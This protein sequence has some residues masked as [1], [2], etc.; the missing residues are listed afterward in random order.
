MFI[1]DAEPAILTPHIRKEKHHKVNVLHFTKAAVS[2]LILPS[3]HIC[4]NFPPNR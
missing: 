2:N 3:F 4:Y 1:H